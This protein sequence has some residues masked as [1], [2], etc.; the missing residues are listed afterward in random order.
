MFCHVLTVTLSIAI[1]PWVKVMAHLCDIL[2]RSNMAVG[3]YSLDT[4]LDMCAVWP[5]PL[6]YVIGSRSWHNLWSWTITVWN[7]I[8]I[9]L[10]SEELWLRN[11]FWVCVHCELGIR[12]MTLGQGHGTPETVPFTVTG[13]SAT[14][15]VPHIVLRDITKLSY[16]VSD[17]KMQTDSSKLSH[18]RWRYLIFFKIISLSRMTVLSLNARPRIVRH[19]IFL[20]PTILFQVISVPD[21][22]ES[23]IA[24]HQA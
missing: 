14:V 5:W 7:I 8:Q 16:V 6:R 21:F 22:I 20:L 2:S 15:G 23:D 1:W 3:S 10:G 9:Q 24:V 19:V 4:V 12:D 13:M 17:D 18:V 11:R